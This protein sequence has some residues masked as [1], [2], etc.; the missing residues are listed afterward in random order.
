MGLFYVWT[1]LPLHVIVSHVYSA[2]C[3][4]YMVVVDVELDIGHRRI[5]FGLIYRFRF[6][7]VSNI[8]RFLSK[9]CA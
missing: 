5:I 4:D 1:P 3:S 8:T 7:L 9:P 6:D 2:E